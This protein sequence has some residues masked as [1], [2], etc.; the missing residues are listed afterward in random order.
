MSGLRL[1][2]WL[3][4]WLAVCL[5]ACVQA[6]LAAP[7]TQCCCCC[8]HCRLVFTADPRPP[9]PCLP[10]CHRAVYFGA[11]VYDLTPQNGLRPLDLQGWSPDAPIYEHYLEQARFFSFFAWFFVLCP[12]GGGQRCLL[13][14]ACGGR[15]W[16]GSPPAGC[17][18]GLK[19]PLPAVEL[20][21]LLPAA[22]ACPQVN[23]VT[24]VEVGVWKGLSTVHMA[25]W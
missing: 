3:P 8:H 16:A 2:T 24:V 12:V 10:G 20:S 14:L 19:L 21:C 13:G 15:S 6:C 5:P 11:P 9:L 4:A 25:D 17:P 1:L 7:A 23:A 22:P 18:A